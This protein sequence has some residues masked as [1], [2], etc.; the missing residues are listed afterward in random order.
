MFIQREERNRE[1]KREEEETTGLNFL[2]L[3]LDNWK[4][5]ILILQMTTIF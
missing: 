1:M 3:I 2:E 4:V 5:T